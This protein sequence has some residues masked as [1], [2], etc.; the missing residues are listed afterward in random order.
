MTAANQN[1]DKLSIAELKKYDKMQRDFCLGKAPKSP[2]SFLTEDQ[3]LQVRGY[4][5][6][7]IT[8]KMAPRRANCPP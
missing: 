1:P 2:G 6:D 8:A 4:Q 3:W 5:A 7:L